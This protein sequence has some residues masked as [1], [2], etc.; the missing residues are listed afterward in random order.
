MEKN[1]LKNCSDINRARA[2]APTQR[3]ARPARASH[4]AGWQ[5]A[6]K[7]RMLTAAGLFF[8]V[9][10]HRSYTPTMTCRATCDH[11]HSRGTG[12]QQG[13]RGRGRGIWQGQGQGHLAGSAVGAGAGAGAGAFG[14]VR[15][16]GRVRGIRQ[17]QGQGHSAG[18]G[19]GAFGSV[20]GI[21][22][23]P[24]PVGRA[25]RRCRSVPIS[26]C[27]RYGDRL[28]CRLLGS[29]LWHYD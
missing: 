21:V 27:A 14:R 22:R 29:R 4:T 5:M 19:S 18:S 8:R 15:V 13:G 28:A 10:K 11:T 16:K 26:V 25:R 20:R 3:A 1:R 24:L 7:G 6:G 9:R 17:G 23:T 2:A 12:I